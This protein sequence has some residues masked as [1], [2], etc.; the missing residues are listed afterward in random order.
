MLNI[1]FQGLTILEKLIK[2][3]EEKSNQANKAEL[4]KEI[5]DAVELAKET[6]DTSKIDEI[7]NR[8]KNKS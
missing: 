2:W 8:V 1:I 6:K 5:I 3:L 4:H 7:F